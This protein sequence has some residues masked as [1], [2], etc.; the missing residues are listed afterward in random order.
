MPSKNGTKAITVSQ[1]TKTAT[2]YAS[3]SPVTCPGCTSSDC[4]ACVGMQN[5]TG[6]ELHHKKCWMLAQA[7]RRLLLVSMVVILA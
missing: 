3:S 6:L 4:V 7:R 2:Q 5:G 1:T